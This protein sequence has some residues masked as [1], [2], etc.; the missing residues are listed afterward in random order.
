LLFG[1]LSIA[2]LCQVAQGAEYG[3][4]FIEVPAVTQDGLLTYQP[5]QLGLV[6]LRGQ[7]EGTARINIIASLGFIGNGIPKNINY[8]YGRWGFVQSKQRGKVLGGIGINVTYMGRKAQ[9]GQRHDHV[10]R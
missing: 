6:K 7:P 5:V 9:G 3:G 8:T 2:L 1:V 4:Y 10:Y